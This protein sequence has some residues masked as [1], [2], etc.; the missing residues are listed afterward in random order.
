MADTIKACRGLAPYINAGRDSPFPQ[1]LR[2]IAE[3]KPR[4]YMDMAV[5]QSRDNRHSLCINHLTSTDFPWQGL[6]LKY[7]N[8]TGAIDTD[9]HF[10]VNPLGR[11]HQS[12]IFDQKIIT[13][14]NKSH[15]P[16]SFS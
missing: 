11:I 10:L 16:F 12:S 14:N 2:R 6:R 13:A 1:L 15:N 8:N 9:I 7:I 4:Q 3:T 5:H